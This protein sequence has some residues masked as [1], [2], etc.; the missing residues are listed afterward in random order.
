MADLEQLFDAL[1]ETATGK[2]AEK[3]APKIA[4]IAKMWPNGPPPNTT[5]CSA[6]GLAGKH[7]NQ[8][9]C[10]LALRQELAAKT[11]DKS[12]LPEPEIPPYER[13]EAYKRYV[14][15]ESKNKGTVTPKR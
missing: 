6:C 9:Y 15:Q 12:Y 1:I 11:G 2:P 8:R 7:A 4:L 14:E 13:S 5:T 3:A 10:V